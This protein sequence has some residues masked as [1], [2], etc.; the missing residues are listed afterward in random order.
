MP[1][2]IEEGTVFQLRDIYYNFNDATIR[3]DARKGLEE[4]AGF[5]SKHP[6][7]EIELSSHTDSRGSR[8]YNRDLSQRRAENAVAYLMDL[9]ISRSRLTPV[10]Y[11]EMNL[12]NQC[13]D[14]V[15]CTEDQHLQN[16]RTEVKI[17]RMSGSINLRRSG[18]D[19]D[20]ADE[21]VQSAPVPS[22]EQAVVYE[23]VAGAFRN[24][25]YADTR[26]RELLTIGYPNATVNFIAERNLYFV[27]AG[28]FSSKVEANEV[29]KNLQMNHGINSFLKRK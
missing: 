6:D 18:R 4:L 24:R 19:T 1:S 10:G 9:G 28:E 3:P 26:Q 27:L 2:R 7:I 14:G 23:V 11:G 29:V 8:E 16:R 25:E 21:T 12:T 17:T 13:A 20:T 5:L 15:R 22:Y